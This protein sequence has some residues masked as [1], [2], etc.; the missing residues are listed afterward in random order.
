LLEPFW[1]WLLRGTVGGGLA[2]AAEATQCDRDSLRGDP[3]RWLNRAAPCCP[4]SS[5]WLACR[6]SPVA[7][8]SAVSA[9]RLRPP[10]P[11]LLRRPRRSSRPA[12][13]PR[14]S[15]AVGAWPPIIASRIAPVPRSRR[16]A[17]ARSLTRLNLRQPAA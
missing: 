12:C 8:P 1:W 9:I 2:L 14:R 6:C 10:P 3:P 4:W 17:S 11:L 7:I 13:A 5:C 16:K 15:S